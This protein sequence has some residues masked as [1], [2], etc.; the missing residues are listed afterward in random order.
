ME[1]WDDL[2]NVWKQCDSW[3]TSG[4]LY[5]CHR[6]Y[7]DSGC[8]VGLMNIEWLCFLTDTRVTG[9]DGVKYSAGNN[10]PFCL[11]PCHK[12]SGA[13]CIAT[14]KNVMFRCQVGERNIS[15]YTLL[16]RG[17]PV[18]GQDDCLAEKHTSVDTQM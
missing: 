16:W 9:V 8:F 4:C 7:F 12:Q 11:G 1:E 3:H 2:A 17:C 13:Q 14:R 18:L 15:T 10:N 6:Q 5:T